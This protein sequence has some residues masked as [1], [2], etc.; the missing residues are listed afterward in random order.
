MSY[1]LTKVNYIN[2]QIESLDLDFKPRD[3]CCVRN[4]IYFV[5]EYGIGRIFDN[6]IDLD[7]H[8]NLG[9]VEETDLTTLSSITFNK[10]HNSLFIVAEN[11]SQIVK[12]KLDMLNYEEVI[13]RRKANE[14]KKKYLTSN[15]E[16]YIASFGFKTVWSVTNCH[17]CFILDEDKALPLIGC[18]KPGF[19]ISKLDKS[20][21][22]YPKGITIMNNAI[23]FA[24]SGNNTLR[25]I[26]DEKIYTIIDD[27][28]SLKDVIFCN[29]KLFFVN[30]NVI[31][32]LSSEGDA[33]HLFEVY[34][35][36]N[37]ICSFDILNKDTV[38]VLERD[39]A[40][41]PSETQNH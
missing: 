9:F 40:T 4:E 17:R 24:D 21:I 10:N 20:N 16:T 26:Q 3:F 5:Y 27:C 35:S 32:M 37:T 11:G 2:K 18:G 31:H 1:K 38:Y 12:I 14:F 34:K 41:T 19:S 33:S 6:V 15:S 7:W 25:G 22:C 23:Y 8:N 28:D 36:E 39:Y 13:P 30:D 29:N